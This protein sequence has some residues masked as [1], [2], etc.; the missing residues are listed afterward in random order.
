MLNIARF[1]YEVVVPHV[2]KMLASVASNSDAVSKL[3]LLLHVIKLSAAGLLQRLIHVGATV[4]A[5]LSSTSYPDG[6]TEHSWLEVFSS[7]QKWEDPSFGLSTSTGSTLLRDYLTRVPGAFQQAHSLLLGSLGD[8]DLVDSILSTAAPNMPLHN[9]AKETAARNHRDG[10]EGATASTALDTT[11]TAGNLQDKIRMIKD[12]F[13]DLGTAF[14]EACLRFYNENDSEVIDALLQDNLN[15]K[16][17]VLDRSIEAIWFGKNRTDSTFGARIQG[18]SSAIGGGKESA[19][20]GGETVDILAY[21][22]N[23]DFVETQKAYVRKM[24][25]QRLEDARIIRREYDDDYD[26]QVSVAFHCTLRSM[27]VYLRFFRV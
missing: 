20:S 16:L 14:I 9:Q 18:T 6:L 2:E 8:S 11:S 17:S 1:P 12:M 23:Q 27:L 22:Q 24:E 19:S 7:T 3:R 21:R 26:D 25:A 15:P 5:E 4:S 10:K 13:P